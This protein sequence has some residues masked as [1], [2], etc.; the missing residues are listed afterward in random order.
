MCVDSTARVNFT[1]TAGMVSARGI[2][3]GLAP[4][5]SFYCVI[6]V[7]VVIYSQFAGR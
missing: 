5:K 1:S 7:R 2:I 6:R 3:F 4:R